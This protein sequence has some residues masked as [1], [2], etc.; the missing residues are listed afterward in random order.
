M[1]I[2]LSCGAIMARPQCCR[3]IAAM[4]IAEAFGPV[5]ASACAPDQV[6]ITLDEFEAVRLADLE[7]RY[8]DRAAERMGVSRPTFSRI[9]ESAH[10]RIAEALVSGKSLRIEGGSVRVHPTG[11]SRCRQCGRESAGTYE[12]PHCRGDCSVK[13][14]HKTGSAASQTNKRRRSRTESDRIT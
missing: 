10:R 2:M 12:C 5:P 3:R 7:E 6:V 14:T 13:T 1:C 8:L 9:I 11:P 4:P